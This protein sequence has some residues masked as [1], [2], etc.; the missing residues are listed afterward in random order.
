[1]IAAD[2]FDG[3]L[4]A[5]IA[6]LA[7]HAGS[8]GLVARRDGVAIAATGSGGDEFNGAWVVGVPEDP[9]AA[10]DWAV[11]QLVAR[12]TPFMVQVP[13]EAV[14]GVDGHLRGHGLASGAPTPGMAR[15]ATTDVPALPADL[16][17]E[18]VRAPEQLEE[19]TVTAA[20]G[21]GASDA[22]G[23]RAV[24]RPS[25]LGDDRVA[26][27]TGHVAGPRGEV[28]VATSV[29][30]VVDGVAGVYGVSVLP[31]H[32]RRGIGAALTWAAV[33]R[34]AAVGAEVVVLQATD[35]GRPV[36]EAMGFEHV[37]SHLRYRR[38]G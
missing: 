36:Y 27:F 21:F 19:N 31:D 32:R 35:L 28:A 6:V 5:S 3:Q 20:R 24:L 17:I 29:C 7:E 23:M 30:V 14:D 26:M 2:D 9:A 33:A 15:R 22:R 38:A 10:L 25:L 16:R 13:A 1:M 8:A 12:G 34:A 37:R 4:V 18:R 11:G